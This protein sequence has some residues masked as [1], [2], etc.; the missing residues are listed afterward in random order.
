LEAHEHP[1]PGDQR[2]GLDLGR[3]GTRIGLTGG[4]GSAHGSSSYHAG[5]VAALVFAVVL[6]V[7]GL[8]GVR[9]ELRKR[10]S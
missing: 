6:L 3:R 1:Q 2:G 8:R 10:A 9:N 5:Q 7:A 4:G